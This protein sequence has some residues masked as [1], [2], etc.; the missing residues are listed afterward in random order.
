MCVLTSPVRTLMGTAFAIYCLPSDRLSFLVHLDISIY[1]EIPLRLSA[2]LCY[3]I[4]A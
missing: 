1:L 4:C 2:Y 3:T